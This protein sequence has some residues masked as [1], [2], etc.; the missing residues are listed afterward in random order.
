MLCTWVPFCTPRRSPGEIRGVV[1]S[2]P[3]SMGVTIGGLLFSSR[4]VGTDT[5]TGV[6]PPEPL[7]QAEMGLRNV[8]TLL[9]QGGGNP[10]SLTQVTAFVNDPSY[11]DAVLRHWEGMFP[12]E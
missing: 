6:T 8:R 9:E 7:R 1:R 11:R 3:M 12:N 2:P 10:A 4:I 5:T